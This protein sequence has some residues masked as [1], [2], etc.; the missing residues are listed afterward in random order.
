MI[1]PSGEGRFQMS[2]LCAAAKSAAFG[3]ELDDIMLAMERAEAENNPEAMAAAV[4]RLERAELE[5]AAA[6]QRLLE[7]T[8]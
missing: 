1:T 3:Q 4:E 8:A 6:H 5:S 2:T 7:M